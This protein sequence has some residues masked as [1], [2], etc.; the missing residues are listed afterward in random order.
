MTAELPVSIQP[1]FV[2]ASWVHL[3]KIRYKHRFSRWA[4]SLF[5]SSDH[6]K[7]DKTSVHFF[8]NKVLWFPGTFILL[9]YSGT[10]TFVEKE[11]DNKAIRTFI[12]FLI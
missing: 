10:H 12:L 8:I 4:R 3:D 2:A 6:A 7:I 5:Y 9:G 11:D 1:T